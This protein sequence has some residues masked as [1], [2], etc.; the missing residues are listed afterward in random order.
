MQT[1]A[2]AALDSCRNGQATRH[3]VAKAL[4]RV[5]IS[6]TLLGNPV[7]FDAHHELIGGRYWMYRIEGGSY[8]V[9]S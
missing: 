2:T 3:R 5:R 6:S 9:I 1:V 4:P 7:S 8:Q